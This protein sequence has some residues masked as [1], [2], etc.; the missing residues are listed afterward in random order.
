MIGMVGESSSAGISCSKINESHMV[1]IF[2]YRG[3]TLR[4]E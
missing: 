4:A 1:L 2:R 3:V